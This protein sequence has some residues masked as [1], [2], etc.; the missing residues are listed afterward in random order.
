MLIGVVDEFPVWKIYCTSWGL[1]SSSL[2]KGFSIQTI[3][4]FSRSCYLK[5]PD[6]LSHEI[7][8]WVGLQ[9]AISLQPWAQQAASM[10]TELR[11]Y[12]GTLPFKL[13]HSLNQVNS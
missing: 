5:H 10:K 6:F 1:D 12:P 9:S 13:Q 8:F 11:I 2:L 4:I 3:D 7:F